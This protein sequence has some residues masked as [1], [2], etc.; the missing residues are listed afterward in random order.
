MVRGY[1]YSETSVCDPCSMASTKGIQERTG[2]DHLVS[3]PLSRFCSPSNSLSFGGNTDC[4]HSTRS[5]RKLNN[6]KGPELLCLA[7]KMRKFPVMKDIV[8]KGPRM[9][10]MVRRVQVPPSPLFPGSVLTLKKKSKDVFRIC[11]VRLAV[12]AVQLQL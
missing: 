7:L 4:K 12:T 6:V 10:C 11:I 5:H 1:G 2:W 8:K 3:L 9:F